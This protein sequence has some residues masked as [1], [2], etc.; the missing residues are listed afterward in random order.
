LYTYQ[1]GDTDYEV[2]AA[3]GPLVESEG[4]WA[5]FGSTGYE[6]LP[7]SGPKTLALN[8]PA[9]QWVMIGNSRSTPATVTGADAVYVYAGTGGYV[10]T[11]TLSPG[12]GAWAISTSGSTITIAGS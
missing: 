7:A 2:L 6:T 11:S 9:L 8:V 5:Y 10:A 3:D 4:Y 12:Q 1:P